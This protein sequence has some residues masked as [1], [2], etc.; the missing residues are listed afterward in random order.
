MSLASIRQS[1]FEEIYIF[2]PA[3]SLCSEQPLPSLP[4]AFKS[5][6]RSALQVAGL[7]EES[8]NGIVTCGSM[9]R[10]TEKTGVREDAPG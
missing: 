7:G 8:Q 9:E 3:N 5:L 10:T 1:A 4:A 6:K 2:H